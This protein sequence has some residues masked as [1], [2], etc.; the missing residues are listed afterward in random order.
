MKRTAL[1]T[2][3]FL[4]LFVAL[5]LL[6]V[7]KLVPA[8]P[9][10]VLLLASLAGYA[11]LRR[12]RSFDPK[13]LTNWDTAR[14]VLL[15]VMLRSAGLVLVLGAAVAFLARD[16]MFLFLKQ[17]PWLWA[18][19][20]ILY[21]VL[22]VYPQELIFRAFFFQ[23]YRPL[24]HRAGAQV[25]ASATAFG[26]VHIVYGNWLAVGLS[27]LGGLLFALTYVRTKSSLLV[28]LEHAVFGNFIFTVGLGDYF[29][30]G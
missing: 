16:R 2:I 5:P 1:L 28:A 24:F 13:W 8:G 11:Y 17:A 12:D 6:L 3:E 15:P 10:P 22:S 9:I 18:A 26:F 20:M 27:F 23:R 19:L 4:L 7:A 25:L 14:H 21:P 29:R 30:Q